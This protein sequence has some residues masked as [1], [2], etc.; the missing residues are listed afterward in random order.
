MWR[1]SIV[2]LIAVAVVPACSTSTNPA[3][4]SGSS[5][6]V[7]SSEP[8]QE[9]LAA[10]PSNADQLRALANA[11]SQFKFPISSDPK[12]EYW[13][14]LQSGEVKLCRNMENCAV[15]WW[16]FDTSGAEPVLKDREAWICVTQLMAPNNRLQRTGEG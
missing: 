11:N 8:A 7:D 2:T 1:L 3:L 13:Y 9:R 6:C 12:F 16:V 5:A 10:A 15:E 4:L 14:R